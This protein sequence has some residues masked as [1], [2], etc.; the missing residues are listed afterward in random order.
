MQITV[1][2]TG[3]F[4]GVHQRLG[5]VETSSLESEVADQVGRIVTELDFFHL[6]K[7][8]Q[9][10]PVQDG[11]H[12]AVQVIDGAGEHTV[13]TAGTSNDPAVTRLHELIE[14]L[15]EAVGFGWI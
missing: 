4:A 7:S 9:A 6:P 1:T 2:K 5:P 10:K 14:L 11:F 8:L 13:E 15:D 12:Y 3:G